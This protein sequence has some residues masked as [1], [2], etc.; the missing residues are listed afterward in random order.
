MVF[1][2]KL[3]G[4]LTNSRTLSLENTTTTGKWPWK[5]V[6][7]AFFFSKAKKKLQLMMSN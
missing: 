6:I 3:L 1:I 4:Y 2:G 5:A 7:I